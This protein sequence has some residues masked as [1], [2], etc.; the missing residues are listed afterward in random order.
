ME[1]NG[2]G[3]GSDGRQITGLFFQFRQVEN[4]NDM[5]G[6]REPAGLSSINVHAG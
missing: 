3:E 6:P 4:G 2:D 5:R 1:V